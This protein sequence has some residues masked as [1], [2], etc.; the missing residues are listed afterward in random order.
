MDKCKTQI[1][2]LPSLLHPSD[3]IVNYC[4]KFLKIN[5]HGPLWKWTTMKDLFE[6]RPEGLHKSVVVKSNRK[7]IS[8]ATQ[9]VT[10]VLY[11][12]FELEHIVKDEILNVSAFE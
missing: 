9:I 12:R 11:C 3:R 8:A 1:L 7:E 4:Y 10:A 2:L 5:I 6:L